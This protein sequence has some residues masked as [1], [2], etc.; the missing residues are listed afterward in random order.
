ML[1]TVGTLLRSPCKQV[2]L[3]PSCCECWPLPLLWKTALSQWNGSHLARRLGM[4]PP[5]KPST[6]DLLTQEYKMQVPLPQS[7]NDSVVQ[8]ILQSSRKDQAE[9]KFILFSSV[10]GLILLSFPPFCW[11]L[12]PN[13]WHAEKSPLIICLWHT[14]SEEYSK[15]VLNAKI[16]DKTKDRS[17]LRLEVL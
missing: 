9:A 10:L 12:S 16:K 11:E 6:N 5:C 3:S 1:N 7:D 8:L 15:I 17:Q 13:K 4:S 2:C 14:C